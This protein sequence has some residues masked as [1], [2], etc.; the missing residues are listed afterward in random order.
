M[1]WFWWRGGDRRARISKKD[2]GE[3]LGEMVYNT[4]F[5]A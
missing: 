5:G 3:N 4:Y 1:W 2:K